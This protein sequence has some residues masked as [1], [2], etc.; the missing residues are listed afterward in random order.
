MD[1]NDRAELEKVL[2]DA[3]DE[4]LKGKIPY[5]CTE[6]HWCARAVL[7]WLGARIDKQT[8]LG[9]T[10]DDPDWYVITD[11]GNAGWKNTSAR[12]GSSRLP[13]P[14]NHAIAAGLT[15]PRVS[16]HPDDG[17][18]L[19]VAR[20]VVALQQRLRPAATGHAPVFGGVAA[21]AAARGQRQDQENSCRLH[22]GAV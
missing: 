6:P 3:M 10:V 21:V 16:V 8:T 2:G 13:A 7:N 1:A 14:S 20:S 15:E 17:T 18:G 12:T 4:W 11:A 9:V 19:V 5:A 22:G